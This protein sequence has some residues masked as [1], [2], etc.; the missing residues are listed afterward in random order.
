M[1]DNNERVTHL[2]FV[3]EYSKISEYYNIPTIKFIKF[4]CNAKQRR[5]KFTVIKVC[6][7]YLINKEISSLKKNLK[8]ENSK[9]DIEKIELKKLFVDEI[10]QKI[11]IILTNQNIAINL[12]KIKEQI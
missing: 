3:N 6:K 10:R 4:K 5:I 12:P 1:E 2:I 11:K 7:D 9:M 8:R